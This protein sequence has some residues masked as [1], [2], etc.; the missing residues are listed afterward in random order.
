M[1][2]LDPTFTQVSAVKV[3]RVRGG[4]ELSVFA[5]QKDLWPYAPAGTGTTMQGIAVTSMGKTTESVLRA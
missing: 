5:F 3:W 2:E 1:Q 4:V